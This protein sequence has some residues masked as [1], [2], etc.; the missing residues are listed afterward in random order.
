MH[1][2]ARIGVHRVQDRFG[3]VAQLAGTAKRYLVAQ[4]EHPAAQ[5]IAAVATV[6]QTAGDQ[7]GQQAV[8][9]GLG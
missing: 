5:R 1:T 4:H 9:G 3:D 2:L 7:R 8:G 6:D